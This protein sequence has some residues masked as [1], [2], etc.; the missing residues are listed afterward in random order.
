[1]FSNVVLTLAIPTYNREIYLSELLNQ[2]HSDLILNSNRRIE[3]LVL[4]NASTDHTEDLVLGMNIPSLR[5]I[6][7]PINIGGD[8]NFINCVQ[9][10]KGE[11]VWLFGDDEIYLPG[12]LD[13][14]LSALECKPALLIVESEFGERIE[15]ESYG[16]LLKKAL[17]LD[18]IF[19]V[20]HTL[21][22]KNIFP[23]FSCS[24]H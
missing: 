19:Q 15:A 18:P 1:M 14:I 21:I 6:K 7:N 16:Y 4:N 12:A 8:P 2:L 24:K 23:K 3:I 13:R 10:A 20:H 22:T 9:H 17:P 11:Y 5:Y